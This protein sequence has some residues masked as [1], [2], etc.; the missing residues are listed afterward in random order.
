MVGFVE[1]SD[2]LWSDPIDTADGKIKE[3]YRENSSR[4]CSYV[5]GVEATQK[6]LDQNQLETVIRAHEAQ[7]EGFKLYS[8][9]KNVQIPQVMTVFSAPNYCDIYKNKAA[10]MMLDRGVMTIQQFSFTEHPYVLPNFMDI[11]SWSLPIVTEKSR[12]IFMQSLR[13]STT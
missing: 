4:N 7:A 12:H 1:R 9:S 6:F 10:I 3:T 8:W 13:S 2:L 11:F 5:F